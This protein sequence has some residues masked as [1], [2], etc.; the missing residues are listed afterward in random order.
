MKRRME[1]G[2]VM[3]DLAGCSLEASERDR[4]LHPQCGGVILFSRNYQ[5]TA[6]LTELCLEIQRLRDPALLIAVDHE[7]GRV[8][9]F[10][11]GFTAVPPM[12][13]LGRLWDRNRPEAMRAAREAGYLIGRELAAC[14]VDFSFTPVL[15]LDYGSSTV[16]GD[17]ALHSD[18]E[19]VS[20]L[21]GSLIAGLREAGVC[22]V[23]KHFPGHGYVKADSHTD[24]PVDARSYHEIESADLIPFAR[25]AKNG[26]SAVMPAH[27]IYPAVDGQPAGFSRVWLQEVLRGQL[28]FAGVIFSDDLTMEG[29]RIAG[30]IEART[31][32]ALAAGCD[33]VLVCNKPESADEV[34]AARARQPL[35]IGTARLHALRKTPISGPQAPLGDDRRYAAAV[36][37]VAALAS[38]SG[39]QAA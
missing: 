31:L 2:P 29:A 38:S 37:T 13:S 1:L 12:R 21:G 34:L 15:D 18:P 7:G 11:N 25:L 5:N 26:L 4:L 35:T 10:R 24:V 8:Q 33:M 23:G 20:E 27:V 16:I 30:G 14:G 39:T 9:R 32:A 22:S 6:Q 3:L 19:A 28:G 36:T 17:R